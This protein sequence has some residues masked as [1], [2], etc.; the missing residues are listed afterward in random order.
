MITV[1]IPSYNRAHLLEKILP[2]YLQKNVSKILLIDDASTDN[3]SEI[4]KKIEKNIPE[5]EYIRLEKNSKQVFAKNVGIEKTKTEW[6][7]FGDDDSVLLPGSLDKLLET[8]LLNDADICGGKALYQDKE[9]D[10]VEFVKKNDIIINSNNI[11]NIK[12]LTAKFNY[13]VK[14]PIEVNFTHAS[15]LVK[16]ELAKKIKF[17]TNY[18]G[19]CYREETDF[20]IRCKL[21]GAKLFYNSD[22]VQVNL[23]RKLATG[24][25]H[26][27]GKLKW[28]YYT[29]INNHYFMKKNWEKIRNNFKNVQPAFLVESK[30][31][32][33]L[34]F[35]AI[36]NISKRIFK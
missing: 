22:A 35:S 3:T 2:T 8:C 15:A 14:E 13:S 30:F 16:T 7:Y 10:I 34:L 12:N 27:S 19:N 28:Y 9:D 20:F 17:D 11:A 36:S 24:G 6:V 33:N 25:S 4:I 18:I 23:P 21:S 32:T 26:S 1:I 29:I 31:I 5:L